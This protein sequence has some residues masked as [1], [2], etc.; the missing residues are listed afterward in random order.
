MLFKLRLCENSLADLALLKALKINLLYSK[1]KA[2]GQTFRS[3]LETFNIEVI[4]FEIS[5]KNIYLDNIEEIFTYLQL[6]LS[7]VLQQH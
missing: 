5:T 2:D 6:F 4:R 1:K 7:L 3:P